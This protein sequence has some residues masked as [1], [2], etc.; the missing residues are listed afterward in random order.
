MSNIERALSNSNGN[1]GTELDLSRTRLQEYA[2]NDRYGDVDLF[3]V[4]STLTRRI[5]IKFRG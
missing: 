2:V 1:T 5:D 3:K 4:S